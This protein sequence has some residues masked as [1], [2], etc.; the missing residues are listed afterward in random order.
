MCTVHHRRHFC[1]KILTFV[2]RCY[3]CFEHE[4]INC[5]VKTVITKAVEDGVD[6][7]HLQ[8]VSMLM[9]MLMLRDDLLYLSVL[10]C[11]ELDD[12]IYK[13]ADG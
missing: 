11:V 8:K 6:S 10:A 13:I 2:G 7:E 4:L 3:D 12:I 9:E 5:L 1:A